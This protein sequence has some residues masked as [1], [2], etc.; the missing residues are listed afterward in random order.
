LEIVLEALEL[1][2][3]KLEEIQSVHLELKLQNRELLL[4]EETQIQ[5]RLEH[6]FLI[7]ELII[8][9]ETPILE[10]R[11]HK[12]Q[13]LEHILQEMT[14]LETKHLEQYLHQEVP[15]LVAEEVQ[16][17]LAEAALL[18]EAEDLAAVVVEEDNKQV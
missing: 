9:E 12:P 11:E 7:Q 15:T 8:Q 3:V 4:Q 10:L 16:E 1:K 14:H 2:L 6:L 17:D 13:N 5:E 18:V